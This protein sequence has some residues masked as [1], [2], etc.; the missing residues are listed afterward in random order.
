MY[1]NKSIPSA[2]EEIVG[3]Y[4]DGH[5]DT[6]LFIARHSASDL[7]LVNAE[8]VAVSKNEITFACEGPSGSQKVVW[9][10]N[11]EIIEREHFL[12]SFFFMLSN[13]RKDAGPYELKTSVEHEPTSTA[14]LKTFQAIVSSVKDITSTIKEITVTG[15]ENFTAPGRD[16]FMF[17]FVPREREK[18]PEGFDRGQWRAISE[19]DRPGAAY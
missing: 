17:V 13:A 8:I 5:P 1:E 3:H 2:I 7:S 19:Q 18:L 9:S 12:E 11:R 16:A 10:S 15:L 6:V 14:A 4:N